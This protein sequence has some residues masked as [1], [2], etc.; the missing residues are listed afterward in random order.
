MAKEIRLEWDT[1]ILQVDE[2][3]FQLVVLM[4][5]DAGWKP[6]DAN[7]QVQVA[8]DLMSQGYDKSRAIR[9]VHM[10]S[11]ELRGLVHRFEC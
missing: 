9:L 11:G 2:D 6:N 8:R 3:E 7:V 4:L 5:Q 10:A 1:S